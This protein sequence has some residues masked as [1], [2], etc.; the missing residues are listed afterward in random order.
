MYFKQDMLDMGWSAEDVHLSLKPPLK[1]AGGKRWLAP[2]VKDIFLST[3]CGR[4]VEPFVGG[5]S[6]TLHIRPKD[7]L[8]NDINPHLYNF[9]WCCLVGEFEQQ[10]DPSRC[11]RHGYPPKSLFRRGLDALRAVLTKP[12]RG[13]AHAFPDFLATFDP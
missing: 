9:Y 5:M 8:L 6:V 10:R 4:L 12:N 3:A 13:L 1:W 2:R 7:A 11:L